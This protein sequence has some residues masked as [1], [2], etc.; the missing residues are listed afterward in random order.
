MYARIHQDAYDDSFTPRYGIV[1]L[2][3][4]DEADVPLLDQVEDVAV[5]APVLLGDLH[6]QPQVGG[7]EAG[8]QALARPSCRTAPRPRAPLRGSSAGSAGARAGRP[9]WSSS[10]SGWSTLRARPRRAGV[11]AAVASWSSAGVDRQPGHVWR[12]PR[13]LRPRLPRRSSEGSASG[14]PRTSTDLRCAARLFALLDGASTS[15][16][17]RRAELTTAAWLPLR[18][19]DEVAMLSMPPHIARP[20][21]RTSPLHPRLPGVR[22]SPLGPPLR[23]GSTHASPTQIT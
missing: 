18:F 9:R 6:D 15:L 1:L 8:G 10:R 23:L 21:P 7:D 4:V 11:A 22:G 19:D 3:R 14:A 16:R 5:G 13:W 12:R 17:V 2:H 20:M